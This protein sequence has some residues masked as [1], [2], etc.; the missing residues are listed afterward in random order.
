MSFVF[1][2]CAGVC[3]TLCSVIALAADTEPPPQIWLNPGFLSYHV[4]RSTDYRE[5]NFGIGAEAVLGPDHG[6]F[7]GTFINSQDS[8][9][10]YGM[11]Q[12]RPL[13]WKVREIG[14]SLG[15]AAGLVDG[16]PTY[17]E[18]GWRFG[19][20]P[21]LFVEGE[22]FGANFVIVPSSDRENWLAA[23][24]FKLRVW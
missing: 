10:H 11:Y 6:F 16:Y 2:T 21:A 13:H 7:V 3:L 18:A 15:L 4:D 22:R 12:W 19:I 1:R 17:R 5:D 20:L 14:V 8:R 9:S 23:I 24:Q